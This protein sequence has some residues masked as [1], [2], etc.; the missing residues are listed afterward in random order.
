MLVHIPRADS[1]SA[2]LAIRI[3]VE[4]A[5][6]ASIN[7][8]YDELDKCNV[9]LHTVPVVLLQEL[10]WE[11]QIEGNVTTMTGF[12]SSKR[13]ENLVCSRLGLVPATFTVQ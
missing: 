2:L 5:A 12:P 8:M 11:F 3:H 10:M 1:L 9:L 13:I 7:A 6:E 4:N